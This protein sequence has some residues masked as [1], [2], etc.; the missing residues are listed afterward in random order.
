[1]RVVR[2][3]DAARTPLGDGV[4]EEVVGPTDSGSGWA[5]T[6]R[7]G[8]GLYVVPEDDL[9]STSPIGDEQIE[10]LDTIELRLVTELTDSVEAARTAERIDEAVRLVVGPAI[11]A[12]E[13]ERHW[14][15]PYFYELDV[16]VRPL[17]DAVSALRALVDA[18][19][20]G[21]LSV[22][23]DG[24]RC[25]LWWNAV[26]DEPGFLVPEVRGAEVSF[27]PWSS[28]ALRPESERPLVS[29]GGAR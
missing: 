27:L 22:Q 1:V 4:V 26:Q 13:A 2:R 18:G 29:G 5:V 23:D 12:I 20:D 16:S 17:V 28:P 21:W 25:D 10:R 8:D 7:I 6:V 19:G 14:A 15:E 9:E 24:W 11:L 3:P